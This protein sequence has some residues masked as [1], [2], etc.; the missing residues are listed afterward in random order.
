MMLVGWD[1]GAETTP[2]GGCITDR[3]C[4]MRAYRADEVAG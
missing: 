4:S 1:K 2:E 3:C